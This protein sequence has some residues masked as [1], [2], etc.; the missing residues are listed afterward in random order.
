M[1]SDRAG[2]LPGLP[3]HF[4]RERTTLLAAGVETW[5]QLA[6]LQGDQLRKLASSGAA[7]EA[8]LVRLRAQA[9]L[10]GAAGLAPHEASLVLHAG[11]AEASALA[12]ADPQRLLVQLNRLTK[13]LLGPEAP[14][15]TLATVRGWIRA[16]G[17][18]RS[19]N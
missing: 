18:S 19:G 16:A 8:R 6:D 12:K 4:H 10:M 9:R 17:S 15:P 7:S 1:N 11:L 3:S 5:E 13:R 14:A 2:G